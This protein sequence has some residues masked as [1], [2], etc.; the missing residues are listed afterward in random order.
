MIAQLLNA[1]DASAVVTAM[2]TVV[3]DLGGMSLYAWVFTGYTL[4]SAV[5]GPLWGRF[6]DLYGLRRVYFA[7]L[8]LLVVGSALCG[9]AHDMSELIAWRVVQ[10]IG[11]G[12]MLPLGYIVLGHIYP[13]EDRP[14]IQSYY[15]VLV[16]AG[17]VLGPIVGGLMAVWSWRWVF[18]LNVPVALVAFV[19]LALWLPKP[20]TRTD[21]TLDMA[22]AFCLTAGATLLLGWSS[23]ARDG[24]WFDASGCAMLGGALALLVALRFIE[25][26]A[27]T[28]LMPLP[29]FGIPIM[30]RGLAL[31]VPLG[32]ALFGATT[33]LPLYLQEVLKRPPQETWI[34]LAPIIIAWMG[35]SPVGTI[36]AIRVGC[37]V[38]SLIGSCCFAGGYLWLMLSAAPGLWTMG[39]ASFLIGLGGAFCSTPLIVAAQ[40]EVPD[41]MLGICTSTLFLVRQVGAALGISLMGTMLSRDMHGIFVM[42]FVFSLLMLPPSALLPQ[43]TAH[44]VGR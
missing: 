30:A 6:S 35:L 21:V 39:S 33:Y 43:N 38:A 15:S 12:A 2:P 34:V 41:D 36:L 5:S 28:P 19:V 26:R 27:T 18:Y 9:Q 17:A 16:G 40:S 8:A 31:M 13:P 1:I 3:R 10:S 4:G 23:R 25:A 11:A 24:A 29:I 22:G 32:M 14:R 7:S 37:R 20:A 42:G 44:H